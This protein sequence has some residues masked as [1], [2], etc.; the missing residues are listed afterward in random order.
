MSGIKNIREPAKDIRELSTLIFLVG[1]IIEQDV[2]SLVWFQWIHYVK[3][4]N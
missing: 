4:M 2:M 1:F 3:V